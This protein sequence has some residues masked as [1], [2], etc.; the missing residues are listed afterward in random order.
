MKIP[1]RFVDAGKQLVADDRALQWRWGDTL[2]SLINHFAKPSANG[3][4]FAVED[5]LL[6]WSH[7]I[8]YQGPQSTLRTYYYT[9]KNWPKNKR[10][11][12]TSWSTHM[13]LAGHSERFDLI[14]PGMTVKAAAKLSG[15]PA[16]AMHLEKVSK[17]AGRS[18]ADVVEAMRA[19]LSWADFGMR[20]AEVIGYDEFSYNEVQV[21]KHRIGNIYDRVEQLEKG[22]I[23]RDGKE[24]RVRKTKATKQKKELAK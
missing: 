5:V 15:R 10:L 24:I 8:D 6:E 4:G 14:K 19:T 22:L 7:T 3:K 11:D 1:K 12:K 18:T 13:M 21:I 9:A 17:Y 23:N 20:T 2:V 16:S